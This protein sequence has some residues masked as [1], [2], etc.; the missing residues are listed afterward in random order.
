[1]APGR[2]TSK[3]QCTQKKK[4]D[5]SSGEDEDYEP[6]KVAAKVAVKEPARRV[7]GKRGGLAQ[8]PSMP[9]D[10]VFEASFA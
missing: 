8:L 4:L 2:R 7:R 3:R 9:L 1:M 6:V 10:V 5:L